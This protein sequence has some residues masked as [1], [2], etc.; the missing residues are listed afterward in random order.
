MS[1][2]DAPASQMTLQQA[3]SMVVLLRKEIR[4]LET[5]QARLRQACRSNKANVAVREQRDR[6]RQS[7]TTLIAHIEWL[8]TKAKSEL[9]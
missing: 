2:Y 4:D 3:R 7:R 9:L 5:E 6:A 8:L 1:V